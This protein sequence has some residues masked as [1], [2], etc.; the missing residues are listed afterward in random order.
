MNY[1]RRYVGDFQRDTGHLCLAEVG[2]YDRLL[3]HYYATGGPLPGDLEVLCRICRAV[4]DVEKHAVESV[5]DQYFPLQKDRKRHNNRADHELA[6]SNTAR[7]NG[8][9]GGRPKKTGDITGSETGIK[10]GIETNEVSEKGGGSVH[11]PT[12]NHQP[13]SASLQPPENQKQSS[14]RFEHPTRDDPPPRAPLNQKNQEQETGAAPIAPHVALGV[15]LRGL[16]VTVSAHHPQVHDWIREGVTIPMATEAVAIARMRKPE[17]TIAPKYLA[18]IIADILD[19]SQKNGHARLPQNSGEWWES[20]AGILAKGAELGVVND[21]DPNYSEAENRTVFKAAVFVAAGEGAWSNT[22]D[23]TLRRI[24]DQI[25]SG[26][27]AA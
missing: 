3:D 25:R 1:Y 24:M 16:G 10:T 4:S 5:V 18:A 6:V 2:A 23:S 21:P 8:K 11:P 26:K 9:G 17:G 13:P 7:E 19:R 22:R 20:D 14:A 12:T 15:K 27:A